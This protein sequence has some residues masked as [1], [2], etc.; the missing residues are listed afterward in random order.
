ME[1][2]IHINPA[3]LSSTSFTLEQKEYLQG[4]FAG[5]AQRGVPFVGH[6]P[7]G[8]ITSDP[9]SGLANQAAEA[10]EETYFGTPVSDLSKEERWKREENPLDIWDKLIAHANENKAPAPDDLFRFKFHGLFYVAPAQDSFMLRLRVPGSILTAHQIRGLAQI[11]ADSGSGRTDI[12]TRSNLQIR[13]LQPKDIV[14][15]LAKVQSLGMTSRGAGADNIRNITAS[16]ITG[17]DPTELYDSA[18][19]A[20]ALNLYILNSRDL[21]GLP[22]KFNVAFDNGGA[23]SVV[24]D[25]NDIGFVAV[26]VKGGKG[27]PAGV[28]FRVLLCGITGHKQFATDCGLLLRP[29]QTVAVAAAIIRVFSENGDRTDRKKARLKYLVD[30]WGIEKFLEETEKRLAFPLIHFPVEACEPRRP[31]NRAGHIGV[32]PQSQPG[33]NYIGVSVPVGRLPV[34]QMLALANIAEQYGNGEVRLTVWQNLVVPNIPDQHLEVAKEAILAAGLNFEA[35]T[36]L[37]GT[38]ACTGNKGCRFSATD[39]KTHAVAL[40]NQLDS[41]FKIEKPMNLHVTGCTHS[42]AQHYIGDIGLMGVK[43]G[44]EEGYQVVIGGGSDQDQGLAR[45]LIPAI[46]FSDLPPV[47]ENLFHAFTLHRRPEESFL[48]FSRRHNIAELKAFCIRQEA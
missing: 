33:L 37:S 36:V 44:G 29:D 22:R 16:P 18:P 4:F 20:D 27:I 19:L 46:K 42:C 10:P 41:L 15:V 7:S 31:I 8:L 11:A 23:I 47:M 13:E 32:H 17:I 45:E 2:Q 1:Q 34:T 39:T 9:A 35:G 12:T 21:Y 38:V 26:H 25:T 30:R 3:T 40:A 6:T 24:A 43:V 5:I 28:Y 14:N 48:D